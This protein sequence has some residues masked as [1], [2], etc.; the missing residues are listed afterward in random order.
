MITIND[1]DD[2]VDEDDI[3]SSIVLAHP[4][5]SPEQ[6][7]YVAKA[8]STSFIIND[9]LETDAFAAATRHFKF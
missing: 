5:S 8:N 2:V 3:A 9:K 7:D 6:P 1:D 4:T